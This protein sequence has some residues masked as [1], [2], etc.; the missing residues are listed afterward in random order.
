MW[1]KVVSGLS[2][3]LSSLSFLLSKVGRS[4]CFVNCA[5]CRNGK[6][7]H[8]YSMCLPTVECLCPR[9]VDLGLGS[10]S[11]DGQGSG[12]LGTEGW[13]APEMTVLLLSS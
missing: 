10:Q 4:R 7:S 3:Y 6:H 9:R 5:C 8:Y 13:A 11:G 12:G 1:S 2:V